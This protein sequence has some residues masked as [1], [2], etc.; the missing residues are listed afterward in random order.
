MRDG[1]E[2]ASP[3]ELLGRFGKARYILL[4][5]RHDNPD[6]HRIQAWVT[7]RLTTRATTGGKLPALVME[8][9]RTDQQ[10]GIDSF[11]RANPG[12]SK[13]LGEA[14]G[15]ARS[16][17]PP[18][19][20]YEPI[21]RPIIAQNLPLLASNLPRARLRPIIAKGYAGLTE[22]ERRSLNL[23]RSIPG[24][25]LDTM[26]REIA[27]SHCGMLT[28]DK[29]RPFTR[30]QILRDAMFAKAMKDGADKAGRAI[31]ITGNGHARSDR[32]VPWHLGRAGIGKKDI[33]ALG[34]VEVAGDMIRAE[35]YAARYGAERLPFD[36]VWFTPR[37]A[38]P[39][40]CAP[41]KNR[42]KARQKK[43]QG[44]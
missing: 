4:G 31:L 30:I 11:R 27:D 5:E 15:W 36:A 25:I 42:K 19:D 17:W 33:F 16:G 26:D 35:D 43:N 24:K 21:V 29:S 14:T 7:A 37:T 9:F 13:G 38:R 40:P 23:H 22:N 34:I 3:P 1:G 39:D 32:G 8:M 44:G 10:A 6:H 41:F 18:W 12:D 28:V 2:F 20:Q